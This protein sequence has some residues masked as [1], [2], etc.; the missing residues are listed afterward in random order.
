MQSRR[1]ANTEATIAAIVTAAR[2]RFGAQGFELTSLEEIAADVRV[3]TGAIYH[4]F[5]SKQGLFRTVAEQIEAELLACAVSVQDP[6]LWAQTLKA[7]ATL[8]EA[9][10]TTEVQRIIFLDAPR[11]MGPEAWREIEMKY[12]FG[13]MATALSALATARIIRPYPVELLAPVLLA[14]LAEASRARAA[15]PGMKEHTADLVALLLR[16]LR[17]DA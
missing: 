6:D 1:D 15:N 7:F 13:A 10:A 5:G 16:A 14:V 2:A 9:C 12:G 3:T 4:H 17:I 8:I 11:V